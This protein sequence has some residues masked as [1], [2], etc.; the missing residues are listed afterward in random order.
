VLSILLLFAVL[1]LPPLTGLT[2]QPVLSGSMEPSIHTG[3]L[4]AIAKVAPE[5]IQT[6]DI[7]GFHVQ[8]M[9]TPVCHRVIEVVTTESGTLYRT[10][11]DANEDADDWLVSPQDIIGK[12]YFNI[13]GLGVIAKFVK[14]PLGFILLMGVPAAI[15]IGM[16]L[17]NLFRPATKKRKRPDLRRRANPLPLVLALVIGVSL[18][19]IP[20][21]MMSGNATSRTLEAI[22]STVSD[23]GQI[24]A[25]RN[26]S[27][28][29]KIPLVICMTAG[30]P[31]VVF[32]ESN[33]R[34]LPGESKEIEISGN[35]G[36]AVIR[37]AGLFPLL[38]QS[39]LYRIYVWN[40]QLTPLLITA[41]WVVPLAA[42]GY[43]IFRQVFPGIRPS[44]RAKYFKGVLTHG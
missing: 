16:E 38:P 43:F 36:S 21:A 4:I 42:A 25:S 3:A 26:V 11:G 20:W 30:D 27:N 7:I 28:K 2:L 8:G 24:K 31:A 32:S 37:T 13:A 22:A 23:T 34:L 19:A 12:V 29:G 35:N 44:Q 18:I 14:T 10:R 17:N 6:G 9:D 39:V 40:P 33:I 5:E 15:V 41:V 1:V